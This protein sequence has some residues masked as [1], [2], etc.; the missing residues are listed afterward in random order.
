LPGKY[1]V[2]MAKYVNGVYTPLA[3]SKTFLVKPLDNTVLP[4]E[5]RKALTAFQLKVAELSRV[6][7]GT[8]KATDELIDRMKYI[9]KAWV[10]T[11]QASKESIQEAEAIDLQLKEIQRVLTGDKSI[12]KRNGAQPPSLVNRISQVIYGMW[13]STS[14]PTQTMTDQYDIVCAEI[15]PLLGKLKKLAEVDLKNLEKAME[16]AKSPWTPGRIPEWTK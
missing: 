11:P 3:G 8:S 13:N 7:S 12:S 2:T 16:Q 14:A 1:T 4:A 10:D 9:N 5:D 15:V 6:V